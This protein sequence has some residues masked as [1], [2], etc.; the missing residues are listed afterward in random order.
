[1]C[2]QLGSRGWILS[3]SVRAKR[4][5]QQRRRTCEHA[6]PTHARF[7]FHPIPTRS[8]VRVTSFLPGAQLHDQVEF[9]SVRTEPPQAHD[10]VV[11][12]CM[13]WSRPTDGCGLLKAA[14]ALRSK[15]QL[16]NPPQYVA[17]GEEQVLE[18]GRLPVAHRHADSSQSPSGCSGAEAQ[19][20]QLSDRRVETLQPRS[21]CSERMP[22]HGASC[23]QTQVQ[24]AP[25]S[26]LHT[27][28]HLRVRLTATGVSWCQAAYT[29]P[30]A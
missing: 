29:D 28:T 18:R 13:V 17:A 5:S 14:A 20:G 24:P 8:S 19:A 22:L 3:S 6:L 9:A 15:P 12:A 2:S 26:W 30:S 4:R 25:P 27:S 7:E 10:V 1:M 16:S 21:A 23:V 11:H